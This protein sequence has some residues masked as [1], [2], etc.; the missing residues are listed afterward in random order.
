M[1]ITVQ[2]DLKILPEKYTAACVL[3][4]GLEQLGYK[5]LNKNYFDT[6]LV[7][8]NDVSIDTL[9]VFAEDAKMNFNYIDDK[10][11]SISIDE[12]DDLQN[13]ND[14]LPFLQKVVITLTQPN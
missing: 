5:Q 6:I 3:T 8:I 7:N 11:L 13:I 1:Y 4:E 10:H 14:I 2:N 9:K 12:K